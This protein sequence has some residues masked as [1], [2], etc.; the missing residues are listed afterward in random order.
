MQPPYF[1]VERVDKDDQ[2]NNSD[3]QAQIMQGDGSE[4]DA[5]F[6]NKYENDSESLLNDDDQKLLEGFS[7]KWKL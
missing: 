1:R 2:S 6:E 5:S 4:P 3:V 7:D